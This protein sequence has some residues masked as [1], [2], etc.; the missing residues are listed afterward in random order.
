MLESYIYRMLAYIAENKGKL[1]IVKSTAGMNHELVGKVVSYIDENYMNKIT[2]Q[3]IA[4]YTHLS[5]PH[6]CRVFK[7]STGYTF[8]KYLNMYRVEKS[9]IFL[10]DSQ[11]V[12]NTAESCGFENQNTYI[13]LF[14]QFKGITPLQYKIMHY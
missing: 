6:F 8:L 13:R 9:L 5:V 1:P 3:D 14:K 12:M 4:D 2:L 11:S 10:N 7:K